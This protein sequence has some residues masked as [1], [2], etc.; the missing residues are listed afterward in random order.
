M[1]IGEIEQDT[2]VEITYKEIE[3][4]RKEIGLTT[5]A[6]CRMVGIATHTY[7][8]W[9]QPGKHPKGSTALLLKIIQE[10]P[11]EWYGRIRAMADGE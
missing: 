6:F 2:M 5:V 8:S 7:Y 4:I 10:N 1:I 11:V 3:T 9:S